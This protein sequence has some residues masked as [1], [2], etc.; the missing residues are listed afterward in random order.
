MSEVDAPQRLPL[1]RQLA[2]KRQRGAR[3]RARRPVHRRGR[4]GGQGQQPQQAAGGDGHAGQ[5][6]VEADE[7]LGEG[8]AAGG[9]RHQAGGAVDG[10]AGRVQALAQVDCRG[11]LGQEVRQGS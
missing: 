8:V 11:S 9:G 1:R 10:A 6:A 3:R 7:P 4:G 2:V 5:E